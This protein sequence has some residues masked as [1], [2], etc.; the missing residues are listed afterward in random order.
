MN[1]SLISGGIVFL[2][3]ILGMY[4]F[5]RGNNGDDLIAQK[6]NLQNN[7]VVAKKK[8]KEEK[9]K[10]EIMT[11]DL[12][13]SF[14]LATSTQEQMRKASEI[15]RQTNFLFTNADGSN[16]E[17]I[18]KNFLNNLRI[19]NERK[20]INLLLAEWQKKM[21]ISSI[22]AMNVQESEQISQ[23][24]QIIKKFIE[25]LS[26]IVGSFTTGN[27]GLS[28]LQIDSYLAQLPSIE[29]INEV[30]ASL[31]TA[32]ENANNPP[33]SNPETNPGL[34]NSPASPNPPPA[35]PP[36]VVTPSDVIREQAIV[37]EAQ[38]QADILQEQLALIEA[39]LSP[40]PAPITPTPAPTPIE[41]NP[42]NNP[43]YINPY[44]INSADYQGIIIQPGPPQL[45]QGTNQY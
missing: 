42:T 17:L 44:N 25:D 9:Q 27:S 19:N 31:G 23:E 38:R 37:A 33:A 5:I 6:N 1:R 30:L 35:Q 2:L 29:V 45:I 20:N 18:V 28:Q 36:V 16:P 24:A 40:P 10:L 26:Q 22:W 11:S 15:V 41:I 4:F 39:Q 3:I 34:Q 13:N 8:L 32:I 12:K 21:D 43:D 7:L 14:P